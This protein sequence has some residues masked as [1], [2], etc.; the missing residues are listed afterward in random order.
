MSDQSIPL[1]PAATG[2]PRTALWMSELGR[3]SRR[4]VF[5]TFM[6]GLIT[7]LTV[8]SV[9]I[10]GLIILLIVINGIGAINI[11]FFIR[12]APDGGIAHAILGS[13]QML[14]VAG[15][16]AIPLGIACS[17]FLSEVGRGWLAEFTRS[18]LD[19][20]AQMPSI[21]VGLFVWALLIH[22]GIT[23]RSGIAGSV[24]LAII[25]LPIVARSV[26]EILRLVQDSRQ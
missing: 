14:L 2:Q 9:S 11:N 17:I 15:G 6:T 21:V 3:Y 4:K 19:L 8:I 7:S 1:E 26:E 13:I 10:L 24:A 16:V 5:N 20:L 23:Q 25:M 22:N 18:I 12:E